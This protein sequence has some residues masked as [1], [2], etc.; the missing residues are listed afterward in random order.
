[1]PSDYPTPT[2]PPGRLVSSYHYRYD[3]RIW[4][5]GTTVGG[6][7][8]TPGSTVA[9]IS[10]SSSSSAGPRRLVSTRNIRKDELVFCERPFLTLQS[11][12]L[13]NNN[14]NNSSSSNSQVHEGVLVCHCCS[15]FVGSPR[16][17]LS[18]KACTDPVRKLR[19]IQQITTATNTSTKEGDDDDGDDNDGN[20]SAEETT[21]SKQNKNKKKNQHSGDDE[22]LIVPCRYKCGHVYCSRMCQND[23]WVYGGH[24]ELCTGWIPDDVANDGDSKSNSNST[25]GTTA[26]YTD[27]TCSSPINMKT[28]STTT[29][30]DNEGGEEEEG[31]SIDNN[32]VTKTEKEST[33]IT[34]G[35]EAGA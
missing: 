31:N 22:F 3:R 5:D 29:S 25:S 8:N 15:C 24:A 19:L 6:S 33:T 34:T 7:G 11:T 26:A 2:R 17:T 13:D 20:E 30:N 14:N 12:T 35:E 32:I 21:R 9:S 1:M 10:S 4:K 28:N 23:D 16:T 27:R 18:I